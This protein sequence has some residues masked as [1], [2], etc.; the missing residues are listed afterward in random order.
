M[1][2][3]AQRAQEYKLFKSHVNRLSDKMQVPEH[4]NFPM[5]EDYVS[6][7]VYRLAVLIA[8][9]SIA[10][11]NFQNMLDEVSDYFPSDEFVDKYEDVHYFSSLEELL[12]LI[13]AAILFTPE[14]KD[15]PLVGFPINS[16]LNWYMSTPSG[17]AAFSDSF[18]NSIIK[19][20][21]NEWAEFLDS[22]ES[23]GTPEDTVFNAKDGWCSPQADEYLHMEWFLEGEELEQ[24]RAG[25]RG[26]D[27]PSLSLSLS[28]SLSNYNC[29]MKVLF[30][31]GV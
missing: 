27:H 17:V 11:M 16:I 23:L 13:D 18:V 30:K 12:S 5:A 28:L 19:D 7:N 26:K 22:P 14:Y 25:Y 8:Q 24:F 4:H 6:I 20:I 9:D 2:K 3:K 31:Y 29:Y 1:S 21:L 10:K 15:T